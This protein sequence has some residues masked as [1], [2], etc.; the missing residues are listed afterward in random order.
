MT[1][2]PK[3]ELGKLHLEGFQLK[4]RT[5]PCKVRVRLSS[6]LREERA[7]TDGGSMETVVERC[8]LTRVK[9]YGGSKVDELDFEVVR[10]DD[11]LVLDISMADS[12]LT[13]SVNDFDNLSEDVF[14][15]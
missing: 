14:R 12:D 2:L 1:K 13:E 9:D 10:D 6:C 4:R 7:V 8:R 3:E 15:C 5:N 11:I